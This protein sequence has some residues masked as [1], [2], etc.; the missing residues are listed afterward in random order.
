MDANE[1]ELI[2]RFQAG[3]KESFDDLMIMFQD[4][5][6]SLAWHLVGNR[7]D[8]LD[9]VQ[10][11]FLKMYRV[12]PRWEPRASLFTWLYRVI[13]NQARDRGTRMSRR[14]WISLE[15]IADPADPAPG[16]APSAGMETSETLSRIAAAVDNLPSRQK[17][18]F[19]LRHYQGL[20]LKEIAETLGRSLGGVK[21]NLHHAV[22]KLRAELVDLL[23]G[24]SE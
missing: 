1:A 3:E 4:R 9:L 5:A 11:A 18:V 21:A 19:V 22:R 15:R 2:R 7:D 10:E 16:L 8:A 14:G 12:L 13:L 6:L 20:Q 24:E 17:E 23:E